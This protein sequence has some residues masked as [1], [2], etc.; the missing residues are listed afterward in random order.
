MRA[1]PQRPTNAFIGA[2]WVALAAG[3]MAYCLSLWNSP[4]PL[5]EKGFYLIVLLFGLFGQFRYRSQCAIA[6]RASW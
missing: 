4:M 6:L 2:S 5:Y 3:G 1:D